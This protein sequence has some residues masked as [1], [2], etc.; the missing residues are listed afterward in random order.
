MFLVVIK[1]VGDS[2]NARRFNGRVFVEESF[3]ELEWF[4]DVGQH[5]RTIEKFRMEGGEK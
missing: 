3:Y 1:S 2:Y 4:D 5:Q